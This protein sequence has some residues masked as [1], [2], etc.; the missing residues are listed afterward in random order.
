[1]IEG[2]IRENHRKLEEQ[3]LDRKKILKWMFGKAVCI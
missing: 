3:G 2:V 1:V